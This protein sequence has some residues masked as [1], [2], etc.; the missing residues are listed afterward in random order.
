M[1][2]AENWLWLWIATWLEECGGTEN[3]RGT[4][5]ILVIGLGLQKRKSNNLMLY[6]TENLR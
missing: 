5:F 4:S 1:T 3:M 6:C 2:V